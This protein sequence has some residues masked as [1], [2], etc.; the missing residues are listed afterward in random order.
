MRIVIDSNRMQSDELQ[1]FLSLSTDNKAVLTEYAAMEAFKGETLKSIQASWSVLR[2]FPKQVI[3]LKGTRETAMIAPE[4]AGIAN[5]MILQSET[6]GIEQF[7][8]L[9]DRAAAGD[10]SI[11]SQLLQRGKWAD[12]HMANMLN[13][14]DKMDISIAE[15]C[16]VFTEAELGR[17]RREDTWTQE[18]MDKLFD[19]TTHLT[20]HS[21]SQHPDKPRWP[22]SAKHLVN[23]FLFRHTL[24]YLIYMLRLIQRGAKNRKPSKA[25]N[26]AI[27]VVFATY[28]SYFNGFMSM[29][30]EASA[31]HAISRELLLRAGARVPVDYLEK[32]VKEI[33][34]QMPYL[35]SET[36]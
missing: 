15:F 36:A 26:D 28:A 7:V 19:L 5:R 30:D 31:I 10:L 23:H 18:M 9:L 34:A 12:A 11:Q 2:Q 3:V 21:F 14:A 29:D 17:I 8:R 16:D 1:I 22:K 13:N 27:D 35:S 24:M 32:Y 4:A 33:A 20:E 6:R 25:R